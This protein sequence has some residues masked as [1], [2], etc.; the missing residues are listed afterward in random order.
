MRFESDNEP[1]VALGAEAA[2]VAGKAFNALCRA[3]NYAIAFR[4]GEPISAVLRYNGR[5]GQ[6]KLG[7]RV[8]M[9]NG[10]CR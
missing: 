8:G 2:F 4:C 6:A 9:G 5:N 3:D 7:K 1:T 10:V